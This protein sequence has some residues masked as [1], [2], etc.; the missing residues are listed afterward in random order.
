MKTCEC[1][2]Q[3]FTTHFEAIE[4]R[5]Q[6]G[7]LAAAYQELDLLKKSVTHEILDTYSVCN[8]TQEVRELM[9]IIECCDSLRGKL[10]RTMSRLL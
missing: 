9:N 5:V 7:D 1:L 2:I 3:D 4:K 10:L 6:T 8:S